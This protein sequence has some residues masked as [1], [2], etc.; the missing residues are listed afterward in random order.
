MGKDE[1]SVPLNALVYV[2]TFLGTKKL[3][4]SVKL[5]KDLLGL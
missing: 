2:I 4:N 1:G 3:T 5:T